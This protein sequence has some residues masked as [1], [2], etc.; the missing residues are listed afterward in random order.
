MKAAL[1]TLLIASSPAL[2]VAMDD[3]KPL[4]IYVVGKTGLPTM[5]DDER[6]ARGKELRA[7]SKEAEKASKDLEKALKKQHGKKRDKWPADVQAQLEDSEKAAAT[8]LHEWHY[9]TNQ[10]KDIDDSVKDLKKELDGKKILRQVASAEQADFVIEVVGRTARGNPLL[11]VNVSPGGGL[12]AAVMADRDLEWHNTF[13]SKVVELHSFTAE[14]PF[15]ELEFEGEGIRWLHAAQRAAGA[16]DK[17][18][19]E[20]YD[21]LITCRATQ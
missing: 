3:Q 1:L 15:W 16:I 18:A 7:K 21:S 20:N 17:F 9:G 8:A 2:G 10:Q 6:K 13:T 12:D 19:K 14:A 4:S 5:S 11:L